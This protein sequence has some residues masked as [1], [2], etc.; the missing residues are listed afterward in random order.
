[1]NKL[2]DWLNKHILNSPISKTI[3]AYIFPIVASILSGIFVSEITTNNGI[4]LKLVKSAKSTYG[5]I[6][7]I[8]IIYKYNRAIYLREKEIERFRDDDYCTAYMRSQCLPEA[9]ER[10]KRLIREGRG[11]ELKQAMDEV[12]DILK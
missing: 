1:M 12:K 4:D 7:L 8:F 11:G 10:Y 9:A 5:L 3:F 2:K 6:F